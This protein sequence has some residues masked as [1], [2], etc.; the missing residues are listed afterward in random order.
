M[1]IIKN[2]EDIPYAIHIKASELIKGKTEWFTKNEMGIQVAG[3]YYDKDKEFNAHKHIFRERTY[4]YTQEVIVIIMGEVL[5]NIYDRNDE[6]MSVFHLKTGDIGIFLQ[7]GHGF[8]VIDDNS[9][10]YEIK[11]GPFIGVKEDKEYIK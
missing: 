7:G 8:K 10:Y 9:V 5:A 2:G 4:E 3:C 11:N 1:E 6:L